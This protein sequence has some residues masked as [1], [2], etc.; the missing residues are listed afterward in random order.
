M[1]TRPPESDK[2]SPTTTALAFQAVDHV[3]APDQTL[4]KKIHLLSEK[5]TETIWHERLGLEQF[6]EKN[7]PDFISAGEVDSFEVFHRFWLQAALLLGSY[8]GIRE[9]GSSSQYPQPW[10]PLSQPQHRTA[11]SS[12]SLSSSLTNSV[13]D[14]FEILSYTYLRNLLPPAAVNSPRR[15]R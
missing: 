12:S 4:G 5:L 9:L 1:G 10:L 2:I 11:M 8:F 13:T 14:D 6:N 15:R 3:L 7:S